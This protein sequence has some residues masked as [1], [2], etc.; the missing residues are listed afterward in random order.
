MP[1]IATASASD[2]TGTFPNARPYESA[3]MFPA[4]RGVEKLG[5]GRNPSLC[6]PLE[7]RTILFNHP[8]QSFLKAL[9]FAACLDQ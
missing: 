6:E 2:W 8:L 5:A 7:D 3:E 4:S 9:V 1:E